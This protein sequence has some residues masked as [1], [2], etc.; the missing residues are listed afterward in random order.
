M[1]A[2]S[3][4]PHVLGPAW[5]RYLA[6]PVHSASAFTLVVVYGNHRKRPSGRG[7]QDGGPN[8]C[9][10]PA[11]ISRAGRLG[12]SS[13]LDSPTP[14]CFKRVPHGVLRR[15]DLWTA[16]RVKGAFAT[17][18]GEGGCAD[19]ERG[20]DSRILHSRCVNQH[21]TPVKQFGRGDE[22]AG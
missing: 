14:G 16:G 10:E 22:W 13:C 3:R 11:Q 18:G 2:A 17:D 12:T 4:S 9:P 20:H 19:V 15:C 5:I 8:R 7:R 21:A 6:R 1:G